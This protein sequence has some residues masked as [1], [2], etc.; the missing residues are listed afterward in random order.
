MNAHPRDDW[1]DRALDAAL[2]ELHGAQP[3][4][5]SAR[6]LGALH[7]APRG[8]LPTVAPTVASTVAPTV[9]PS[10]A[11]RPRARWT[12]PAL[13]AVL[14]GA[15]TLGFLAASACWLLGRPE[16][17]S[18]HDGA[19]VLLDVEV[20]Q[21]ALAGSGL[22]GGAS[23]ASGAHGEFVARAGNRLRSD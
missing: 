8:P 16:P 20:Q 12:V 21:G 17:S 13:A 2:H 5:L 22:R 19:A 11:L 3:P 9:A 18:A 7:E 23:L 4:D 10:L 1:D 6:V 14:L 15:A